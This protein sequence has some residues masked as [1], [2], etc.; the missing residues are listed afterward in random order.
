MQNESNDQPKVCRL[1][2]L[3][4]PR[5]LLFLPQ[6]L[7]LTNRR[8]VRFVHFSHVSSNEALP[9]GKIGSNL[10][11]FDQYRRVFISKPFPVVIR[12]L[13]TWANKRFS[14]V[15]KTI[16]IHLSTTAL[17][18]CMKSGNAIISV[19]QIN[20]LNKINN[21]HN[22]LLNYLNTRA[23]SCNFHSSPC[24]R[25]KSISGVCMDVFT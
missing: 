11:H 14:L 21:S 8:P 4:Q 15:I 23:K 2:T 7:T 10:K 12:D 20:A 17:P 16:G 25:E 5:F 22:L 24:L 13:G 3:V 18:K 6:D 19:R 1:Y 9:G